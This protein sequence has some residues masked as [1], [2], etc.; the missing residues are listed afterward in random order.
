[1]SF[2][3]QVFVSG[4]ASLNQLAADIG[5]IIGTKLNKV[6]DATG[7]RYT[8][9]GGNYFL[10]LFGDHGFENDREMDFESYKYTIHISGARNR[11]PDE[12]RLRI[13]KLAQMIFERLRKLEQYRLMLVEDGQLKIG[14]F[15]PK[16]PTTS[17]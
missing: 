8:V 13:K 15:V 11:K 5:D 4:R 6:S 3:I 12:M 17:T 7:I 10:D 2:G 1:M 9:S 16:P 14:T